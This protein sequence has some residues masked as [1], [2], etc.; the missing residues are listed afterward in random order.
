MALLGQRMDKE[1][2]QKVGERKTKRT[3]KWKRSET[4]GYQKFH[5]RTKKVQQKSIAMSE[6]I[7]H[8]ILLSLPVLSLVNSSLFRPALS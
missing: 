3:H 1:M 8:G 4:E 7:T 5:E 6:G 2:I